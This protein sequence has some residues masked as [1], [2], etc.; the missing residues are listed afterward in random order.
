[1]TK[2]K[3][4]QCAT[5]LRDS[6]VLFASTSDDPRVGDADLSY[7][8]RM[9]VDPSS[10]AA[11]KWVWNDYDWSV[12]AMCLW[13]SRYRCVLSREGHVNIYGPGGTPDHT[14]QIPDTGVFNDEAIGLGY[15][16]RI[17]A[18]GEHLYVC[19]QSR[20][21]WRFEVKGDNLASGRWIDAAGSMRQAPIS[22][23][24]DDL[25]GEALD[26][27]LDDNDAIDL[28]D[29]DGPSE[30]DIYTVGDEAWHFD[31]QQWRRLELP[32]DESLAAIKVI[33]A[34]R[35][36]FV[37]HNGTVLVGNAA[38]GFVDVSS[39]DDNQNL[40]GVEWFADKLFL[41]S[42]LG[43]FTYDPAKRAIERCPT[44]LKPDLQDTHQLE[45]KDGVLWS[46]GF[47]DLAFF[48][49]QSW[50]R[51]DHPDNPKIR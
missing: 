46:F 31:G 40:V 42:N 23:P 47:K 28:V 9:E 19:G 11:P 37:G 3:T 18:I 39:A 17:R 36:V 43:L 22:D 27:W 4:V 32:S 15:V 35:V 33:D 2:A 41:A 16:N 50:T 44:N 10:R 30:Q 8:F 25:E 13:R 21:V 45:A 51:V 14:F 49:G 38:D 1:M 24:P 20:Q 48:D 6:E 5:V 34:K 7:V 12:V 26:Q 29:I